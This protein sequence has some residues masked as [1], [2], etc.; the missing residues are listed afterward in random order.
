MSRCWVLL[1]AGGVACCAQSEQ[2]APLETRA[3]LSLTDEGSSAA[4]LRVHDA[5]NGNALLLQPSFAIR[6]GQRWRFSTSLAAVTA[7][8]GETRARLRVKET[9][10]GYTAGDVDLAIGKRIVK[11]GTGYAF[12]PTGVLDPR[13]NAADP[14]DRLNLNEGREMVTADYVRGRHA[15]TAAWASGGVVQQHRPGM[16]ETFALRYNAMIAGFD[17]SV[18][19][20]QERG[21]RMFTGVNFTRVVG[22]AVEVHGEL[23]HRDAAAALVGG[24]FTA[25]SGLS[26]IAEFYSAPPENGRPRRQYGF[27]NVG[28]SRLRDR[29]GWKEWD[30]SAA[31]V[32]NL[33]DRSRI[34]IFNANRWFGNHLSLYGRAEVP[35]GKAWRSEYGM[36]P[37]AALIAAGFRVNL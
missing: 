17:S 4:G 28:K 36:I 23:A 29:P 19:V 30:V 26:T 25:R 31:L 32:I 15:F 34:A 12:T 8:H 11:W 5:R 3:G 18:V 20:A 33:T 7:T 14:T 2:P 9:Y 1:I 13:R 37:Y 22:E 6:Q 10:F 21:R 16:R 27:V 35:A 24:K